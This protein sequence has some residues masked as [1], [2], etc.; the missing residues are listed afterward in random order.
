MP[1]QEQNPTAKSF[2]SVWV[3]LRLQALA[4]EP[5]ALLQNTLQIVSSCP[6]SVL[7]IILLQQMCLVSPS[8]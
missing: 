1:D 3:F 8:N 2:S 5:G 6:Y 4:Q 7:Q